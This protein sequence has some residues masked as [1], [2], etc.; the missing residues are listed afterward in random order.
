MARGGTLEA[1]GACPAPRGGRY[2]PQGDEPFS[3]ASA[4]MPSTIS[5]A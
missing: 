1:R 5:N 3:A 4:T 2:G